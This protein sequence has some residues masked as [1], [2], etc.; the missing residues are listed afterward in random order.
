MTAT[1]LAVTT[2]VLAFHG[3]GVTA[4]GLVANLFLV[5]WFGGVVLPL[6]LVTVLAAS[7][8]GTDAGVALL[9]SL[10]GSLTTG[11]EQ[12]GQSVAQWV[13]QRP[14]ASAAQLLSLG[15][16]WGSL[17]LRST[18]GRVL[19]ALGA[20]GALAVFPAHPDPEA[21]PRV[22]VL[23]VGQGDAVV[24]QGRRAAVL[25]DG[26]WGLAG[27]GD[28][29]KSVVVPALRALGVRRLDLVVATHADADHRGGLPAVLESIPVGQ[30]WLPRG[31]RADD[32]FGDLIEAAG[33]RG[34]AVVER[35]S[36]DAAVEH[37]DLRLTTLW[38]PP[39]ADFRSRNDGSLVTHVE[40]NG[41]GVLLP[42]DLGREAE[43]E[44]LAAVAFPR[45]DL[46]VVPHH[47]SRGSSSKVF[48]DAVGARVAVV[49]APCR[50]GAR[51]PS[52]ETLARVASGGTATW[53]T[54]RD[55]AVETRL[56]KT[57]TTFGW[58]DP[59]AELRCRWTGT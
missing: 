46:L 30:L 55:G 33:R 57:L 9:C 4:V 40:V 31:G 27:A 47:G 51:L 20:V 56:R 26:G 28:L 11:L 13:V 36:G 50:P 22:V 49:S 43:A 39:D 7:V 45:V 1:A 48:L 15:I 37:G 41:F 14:A 32:A 6:S 58:A 44:L 5:P 19:G 34:V 42:G 8:P 24:I 38:P 12:A 2:P 53:W 16:G 29:G 17:V 23:D 25:I 52:G 18:R 35:A 59:Q 54:G 3:L 21:L 10:V